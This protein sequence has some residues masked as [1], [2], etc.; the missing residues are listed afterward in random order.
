MAT[1]QMTPPEAFN[2]KTPDDW[3]RWRR[4]F[5][6]FPIASSLVKASTV[7]Q[8]GTLLCCMGEISESS[9]TSTN[10]TQEER[11]DYD[12]IIGIFDSFLK[13]GRNLM[14]ERERF[15]R[16]NQQPGDSSEQYIMDGSPL[17]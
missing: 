11:N 2:F 13:V 7:K 5:E 16:R 3:P 12:L 14:F 10:V 9:L 17:A 1:I 4:W 6:Q 8:I 15:N